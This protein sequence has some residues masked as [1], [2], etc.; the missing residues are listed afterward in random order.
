MSSGADIRERE[1]PKG[2]PS[3]TGD[4]EGHCRG[5]SAGRFTG[6]RYLEAVILTKWVHR[7]CMFQEL[8]NKP[9]RFLTYRLVAMHCL[10]HIRRQVCR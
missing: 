6:A 9:L 8:D 2:T 7:W 10:S 1:D 3:K 4:A 5:S